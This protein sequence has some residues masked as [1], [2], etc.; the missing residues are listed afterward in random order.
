MKRYIPVRTLISVLVMCQVFVLALYFRHDAHPLRSLVDVRERACYALPVGRDTLWFA[1]A[2]PRD[3]ATGRR[4]S[5]RL[6]RLA[7]SRDSAEWIST[8]RG[9]R[10][11]RDGDVQV[12]FDS[13]PD[14]W[15]GRTLHRLI[16]STLAAER[17]DEQR[18]RRRV[19]ELDYYAR[20]HTVVDEGYN[21][22]MRHADGEK[23]NLERLH[24]VIPLLEQATRLASPRAGRMLRYVAGGKNYV[25]KERHKG[26]VLLSPLTVGHLAESSGAL[27]RGILLPK[28]DTT[29]RIFLSPKGTFYRLRRSASGW[30]GTATEKDGDSYNGMFDSLLR[31][32]GFGFR[33]GRRMVQSGTW[34]AGRYRGERMIYTSDRVYGIDISRH[35]HEIGKKIHGIDWQR[36]RIIGLG[37]APHRRA[38]GRVDYPVSFV[39]IKATEGTSLLNKYYINDLRGALRRGIPVAPYHFFSHRSRGIDQANYFLKH[40]RPAAATLPAVLDVEPTDE[41]IAKMG[42]RRVLFA[43]MLAWLRRVRSGTGRAP[44]LYVGQSFVDKHLPHA[45]ESL[46]DYDVWIARYGEFRPYVK[47]AFWQLTPEGRVRGIRGDVDVNVFNGNRAEFD[48]WRKR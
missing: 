31:P 13:L 15:S 40:A 8:G 24:K 38:A 22:V 5:M 20:T 45:P 39:F 9:F 29:L 16:R 1:M 4:D 48:R 10:V 42:G 6:R 3:A 47:L 36:L 26:L 44:V 25:P 11:N 21:E 17:I 2:T 27:Q 35:Q 43:E 32:E 46:R 19:A 34:R 30:Q 33:V 41:Q 23:R 14:V 7:P 28:R 18:A 37:R 12:Y